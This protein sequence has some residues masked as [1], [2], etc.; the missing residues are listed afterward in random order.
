MKTDTLIERELISGSPEE[1]RQI[2]AELA[3]LLKPKTIIALY[4]ELGAGKTT[5]VQGICSALNTEAPSSPTFV[6]INQYLGKF[7]VYHIDLYRI[8][9]LK[10]LEELGLEEYYY[11]DG[12]TLIEWAD[13]A[14]NLLPPRRIEVYLEMLHRDQRKIRILN[15]I[16]RC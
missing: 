14:G 1:T 15:N 10:E 5:F 16:D 6:I 8:N 9:S 2:A 11:G 13:R 7:P 12:I 4:G 3:E